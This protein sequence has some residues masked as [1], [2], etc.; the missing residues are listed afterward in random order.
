VPAIVKRC[1]TGSRILLVRIRV[2]IREERAAQP[3]RIEQVKGVLGDGQVRE[4]AVSDQQGVANP[5]GLTRI[6]DFSDAACTESYGGRVRP[7]CRQ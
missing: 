5:G 7:I 3:G 4:S 2:N 6:R 1:H